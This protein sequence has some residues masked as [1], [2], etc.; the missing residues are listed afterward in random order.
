MTSPAPHTLSLDAEA[1]YG[2]LLDGV[3]RLATPD[4]ALVGIWSGG[5]WLAERLATDLGLAVTGG[6][7]FH[8]A[9][10]PDIKLGRGFGRLRVPDELLPPLEALRPR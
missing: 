9:L 1:R 10:M 5:A 6:S 4:T 3:R 2:S 7:D 8:G